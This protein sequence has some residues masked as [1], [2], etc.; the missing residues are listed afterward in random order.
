MPLLSNRSQMTLK[1]GKNKK[2]AHET[3]A[4]ASLILL[5]HL[6]SSEIYY[7]TDPWQHRIYLFYVTKKRK[8]FLMVTSSMGLS[9]NRS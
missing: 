8:M 2:G 6:R 3:Q 7:C 5:P 9:S 4:S 1:Y